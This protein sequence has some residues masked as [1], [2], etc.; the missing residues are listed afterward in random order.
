MFVVEVVIGMAII[1]LFILI[2]IV[3]PISYGLIIIA[4][5]IWVKT[6]SFNALQLNISFPTF[7]I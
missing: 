7:P 4:S 6:K 5:I 1:V 2:P 3:G